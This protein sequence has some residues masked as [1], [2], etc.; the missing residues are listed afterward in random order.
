MAGDVPM[1]FDSLR[2]AASRGRLRFLELHT[3][4]RGENEHRRLRLAVQQA[5]LKPDSPTSPE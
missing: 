5:L 4:M 3:A 2:L 1:E